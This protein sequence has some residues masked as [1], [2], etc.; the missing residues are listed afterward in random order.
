MFWLKTCPRCNGDL[1]LDIN[2]YE[3][4]IV[5]LQCGNRIYGII[6]ARDLRAA[7]SGIKRGPRLPRFTEKL[8]IA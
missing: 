1:F 8:S 2:S 4:S 3:Q 7:R 5:C 6:G